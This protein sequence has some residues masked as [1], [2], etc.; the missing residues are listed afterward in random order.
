MKFSIL[1]DLLIIF[2]EFLHII[3]L[4]NRLIYIKKLL[5]D[6]QKTRNEFLLV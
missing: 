1:E 5:K 6:P 3:L 4:E 2:F